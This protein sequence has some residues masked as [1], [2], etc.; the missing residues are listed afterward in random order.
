AVG[1]LHAI[2]PAHCDPSE[3]PGVSVDEQVALAVEHASEREVTIESQ[4]AVAIEEAVAG[5]AV[6]RPVARGV[7]LGAVVVEIV[8]TLRHQGLRLCYAYPRP[9]VVL[10]HAEGVPGTGIESGLRR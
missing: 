4:C 6:E 5:A 1:D 9:E 2:F 7:L 3:D 8:D 10:A